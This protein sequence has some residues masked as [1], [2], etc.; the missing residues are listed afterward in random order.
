MDTFLKDS[1]LIFQQLSCE[2]VSLFLL[3]IS[4]I[5]ILVFHRL[6]GLVGLYAYTIIAV[7][8]SNFQVLKSS[9][10]G[11]LG[12]PVALGTVL[13]ASTFLATDLITEHY[14][15]EKAKS[16]IGLVFSTQVLISLFMVFAIAFK[17]FEEAS[18]L[19]VH[20]S[21]EILFL[22]S[23]RILVASLVSY[24][25]SQWVDISIFQYVKTLTSGRFL[26]LRTNLSTLVSGF[27]DNLTFSFLAWVVFSPT[28]VG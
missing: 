28:P 13:F 22:P 8:A 25:L 6:Y 27:V 3:L 20:E 12:E 5:G 15:K 26:W 16:C 11:S 1:L 7:I 24:V 23:G 10:F 21:L 9:Y 2:S 18:N 19:K 4:C 14:G 17:P